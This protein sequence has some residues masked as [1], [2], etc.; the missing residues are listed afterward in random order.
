MANT[1]NR[2]DVHVIAMSC[3]PPSPTSPPAS[4]S[5]RPPLLAAATAL[6]QLDN[7]ARALIALKRGIRRKGWTLEQFSR[8]VPCDKST[9]SRALS[10][11]TRVT[12]AMLVA[13]D[14]VV[15]AN[16]NGERAA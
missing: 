15:V 1:A 16:D 9:A 7:D 3:N 13:V 6:P 11:K 10:G 8:A 12:G 5:T 14:A 4:P 2:T